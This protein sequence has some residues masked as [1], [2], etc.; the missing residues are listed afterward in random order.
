MPVLVTWQEVRDYLLSDGLRMALIVGVALASDWALHRL[1]PRLIRAGVDRRLADMPRVEV[2]KRVQT[3]ASVFTGSGRVVIAFVAV[4]LIL[5]LVGINI[6][7][8][9]AGAGVAGLALGIA[10][11]NLVRD[12]I[13]GFFILLENQYGKGDVVRIAGI[14]GLVEEMNLRRT[15]L[16]DLDG[17]VHYVPHGEVRV[18]SNLTK[19]LSLVH[20]EVKVSPSEDLAQVSEVID[21]VGRELAQ[22]A[23]LG[24]MIVSPPRV[25]RMEDLGDLGVVFKVLGETQP[26]KQREVAGEL[27]RRL[28]QALERADIEGPYL[29][30]VPLPR[31]AK[32]TRRRPKGP[33]V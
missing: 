26:L 23:Q 4:L 29:H 9:L 7:P 30:R 17:A 19:A 3:L 22:D 20:L 14:T 27:Q 13:N 10:A 25:L 12:V 15:V 28:K 16:R 32:A 6:A 33:G 2:E 31:G 1:V 18:T 21:R 11:Q 24:P 8:L 5:P